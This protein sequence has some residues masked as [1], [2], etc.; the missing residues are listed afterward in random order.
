MDAGPGINFFSTNQQRLL[1]S[2]LGPLC[3]PEIVERE[4]L[5]K[6]RSDER[7]A[8]AQRVWSKLPSRLME[9]VSDDTT[10]ELAAAVQRLSGMAIDQRL[11]ISRDLGETMVIA[12]AAVAAGAGEHVIILIDDGAGCRLAA[13]EARRLGRLQAAG[14]PVGSISLVDTVTV[15]ERAAGGDHLPDKQSMRELCGR[16]RSLDDGLPPIETTRLLSRQCWR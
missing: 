6:A 8:A 14:K 9:V 5:R 16:L 2:V 13:Q 1:F 12:H 3:V 11:G 10:V 4:I 7:F 15:L